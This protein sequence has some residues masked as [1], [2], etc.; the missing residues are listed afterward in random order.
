MSKYTLLS[1]IKGCHWVFLPLKLRPARCFKTAGTNHHLTLRYIPEDWRTQLDH[2]ES[3]KLTYLCLVRILAFNILWHRTTPV[4][5]GCVAGRKRK[6]KDTWNTYP[7]TLLSNFVGM[8]R[9]YKCGG[10]L[11]TT[12]WRAAGWRFTGQSDTVVRLS[13][14]EFHTKVCCHVGKETSAREC[15]LRW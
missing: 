1:H 13:Q 14:T 5:V 7:S 8:H 4:I 2:C 11:H 10:R 12:D 3:L 15:Q 9:I 6:N